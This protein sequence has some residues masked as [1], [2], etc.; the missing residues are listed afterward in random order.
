MGSDEMI[1]RHRLEFPFKMIKKERLDKLL[2]ERGLAPTPRKAQA[3][4]MAGLV[5]SQGGRLEKPG[6]LIP[7]D[8]EITIQTIPPYVGRGGLKLAEALEVFPV[9]ANGRICVDIGASTGGFTDCLL[10]RGAAR[11]Y[12]VDVDIRQIDQKLREDPRVV[13]IEKNARNLVRGDL[14]EPPDIVVMDVSFIS[15]LKIFPAI[16]DVLA[17]GGL[18]LALL[19]PQFE[20]AK[21]QVGKKG[22][23]RD[24]ALHA[25]VLEKIVDG[26]SDQGFRIQGFLRCSTRGKSGNQEFF[27]LWS[28]GGLPPHRDTVLKWIEEVT[29]NEN[30]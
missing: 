9:D 3:M 15:V 11:V 14:A 26:A 2:V 22:I 18:L 23:V 7:S 19:K 27:S 21:G 5:F 30:D 1:S 10:Q 20:A 6:R 24:R 28:S 17:P 4:I 12:A 16:R 25:E 13:L 29:R 8:L